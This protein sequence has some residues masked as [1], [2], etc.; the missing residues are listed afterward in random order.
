ME[1]RPSSLLW[2][3]TS[4]RQL[5]GISLGRCSG[6]GFQ[7]G[8]QD[9]PCGFGWERSSPGS[10]RSISLPGWTNGFFS[11][12]PLTAEKKTLFIYIKASQNLSVWRCT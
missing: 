1:I 3:R 6:R 5:K 12:T 8:D 11:F 4:E 10:S 2:G 9:P 7:P